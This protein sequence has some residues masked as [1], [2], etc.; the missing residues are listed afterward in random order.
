MLIPCLETVGRRSL[1][2]PPDCFEDDLA[3]KK[4]ALLGEA[5][6]FFEGLSL[7]LSYPDSGKVTCPCLDDS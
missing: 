7:L 4:D 3:K 1:T 6:L 2:L 5:S